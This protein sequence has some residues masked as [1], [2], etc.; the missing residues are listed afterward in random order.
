MAGAAMVSVSLRTNVLISAGLFG[1]ILVLAIIGNVLEKAGVGPLTGGRRLAVMVV[2]F[3]LFL[4]FGFSL[5][6]VMVK[7]VLGAQVSL[8]NQDVAVVAAALRR[9][10]LI[11]WVLW[12]LMGAGT[13]VAGR[14]RDR[15]SKT[16]ASES[17]DGAGGDAD[18]LE[19]HALFARDAEIALH[20]KRQ[21]PG[22]SDV[23]ASAGLKRESLFA[24]TGFGEPFQPDKALRE[25]TRRADMP[26]ADSN[27]AEESVE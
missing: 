22:E 6:P 5:V 20:A 26:E 8:G 4:A 11:I 24:E 19:G 12:A 14:R 9:Q 13:I 1:A 17:E 16:L 2:F 7:T 10:H 27:A 3:G 21:L 25:Q 18:F 23:D 15:E